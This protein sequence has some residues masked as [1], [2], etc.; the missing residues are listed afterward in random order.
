MYCAYLYSCRTYTYSDVLYECDLTHP[1]HTISD[2]LYESDLT[3]PLRTIS[4]VLYESDL[5]H[6]LHQRAG[7]H[8][9]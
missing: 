7:Y 1:L 5:T 8:S 2:V 6:L 3:H 9:V 4:D